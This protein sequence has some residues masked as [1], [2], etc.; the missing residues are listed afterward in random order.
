MAVDLE[1]NSQIRLAMENKVR[2]I[3][4]EIIKGKGKTYF[5]MATCVCYIADAILNQRLTIAPVS[6]VLNGEYSIYG[7]A[8]RVP[9]IIG[10]NVIEIGI[11]DRW[12]EMEYERFMESTK[13]LKKFTSIFLS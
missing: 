3:G 6:S 8:L 7:V 9:S 1:W 4:A 11:E 2:G 12:S 13:K 5:G 10:V